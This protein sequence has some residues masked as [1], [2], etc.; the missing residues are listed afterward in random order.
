MNEAFL[1]LLDEKDFEFITIRELCQRAKVNRSTFYLHYENLSDLLNETVQNLYETFLS[2]YKNRPETVFKKIKTARL[3]ELNLI[4]PEYLDP[5]L[6]FMKKNS[7]VLSVAI[8]RGKTINTAEAYEKLFLNI[9]NPVLAL[10]GIPENRRNYIIMFYMNEIISI[11]HSWISNG[12]HE[13]IPEITA[14]IMD[15]IPKLD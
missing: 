11:V 7:R 12:C 9:L 15:C 5:Y 2:Y 8:K 10:Y 4:R 1:E 6:K 14:I 3:N 13:S